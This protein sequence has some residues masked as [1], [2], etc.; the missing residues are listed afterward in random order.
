[1]SDKKP[2]IMMIIG[3]LGAGGKER[4]L[5]L[6]LKSLKAQKKYSTVL[7]VMNPGGKR[8]KEA[9]KYS[10]G[11]IKIERKFR[12]NLLSVLGQ[13]IRIKKQYQVD[14][15]HSWGSGLW[16][17]ISLLFTKYY[18][19]PFLHNGIQSAPQKLSFS[20]HLSRF[21]ALFA[22]EIVANS[23][24]GLSAFGLT[25]NPKSKVIFNGMDLERFQNYAITQEHDDLC[26]VANFREEKD[27]QTLIKAIPCI[28]KS[29]PSVRLYL[30]GHDYGT[31]EE[32]K[33]LVQDLRLENNVTFVTDTLNP[34]PY[35]A[36]SKVC[37]L[38]THGEGISNVL[39]EYMALKKPII[40]SNNGGN[41]EVVVNGLN[42]YLV[43]PQSIGEICTK[44][45]E[46]LTNQQIAIHMGLVGRK[47]V[48]EKFS[49]AK[50]ENEFCKIYD[51]LIE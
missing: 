27:H 28:R 43:E 47:I 20:D 49:L 48:E 4:Q 1:M 15:V 26:M 3:S 24:A 35:I 38:A 18:R 6:H 46:L 5:I 40:V 10:D 12:I 30:V 25:N 44:T 32:N 33:K 14:I 22:N 13:L 42:G 8:E 34:E 36:S 9:A 21:S 31:L 19:I 45:I 39:L 16:D 41:P 11:F 51:N 17:L 23:H 2:V 50:M 37:L 7:V 29:F